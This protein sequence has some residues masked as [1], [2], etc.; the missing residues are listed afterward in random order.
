MLLVA[1]GGSLV[2]LH[3]ALNTVLPLL[4]GSELKGQRAPPPIDAGRWGRV[5]AAM[6]SLRPYLRDAQPGVG[7]G[8]AEGVA[9]AFDGKDGG[10]HGGGGMDAADL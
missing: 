7:A 9:Q 8:Q 4:P 5:S 6:T 2:R 3:T 10:G 1:L